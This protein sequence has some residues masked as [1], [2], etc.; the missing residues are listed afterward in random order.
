[1]TMEL[2]DKK[3]GRRKWLSYGIL[4]GVGIAIG[5]P[6]KKV[7]RKITH[8]K[9]QFISAD[10]RLFEIET[11]RFI[12]SKSKKLSNEDLMAWMKQGRKNFKN[13]IDT[14]KDI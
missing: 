8:R 9:K 5:L 2:N 13:Q 6:L 4:T 14:Q 10:G 3:N 1:M 11:S 7:V 12:R